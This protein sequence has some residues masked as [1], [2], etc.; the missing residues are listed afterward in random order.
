MATDRN[1]DLGEMSFVNLWRNGNAGDCFGGFC[2]AV[3]STDGVGI[4]EVEVVE[5]FVL[6]NWYLLIVD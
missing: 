6:G 1:Y 5:N 3:M 4:L 2:Y